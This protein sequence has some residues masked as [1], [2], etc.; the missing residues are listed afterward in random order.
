LDA[1]VG[2]GVANLLDQRLHR[3]PGVVAERHEASV[4]YR[5][6]AVLES[7][8][9]A[10][11]VLFWGLVIGR[12]SEPSYRVNFFVNRLSVIPVREQLVL[13]EEGKTPFEELGVPLASGAAD[14]KIALLSQAI[15]DVFHFNGVIDVGKGFLLRKGARLFVPNLVDELKTVL[16]SKLRE[17]LVE[18]GRL[19][20]EP[21]RTLH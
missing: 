11:H 3:L 2:I 20:D 15:L 9:D 8:T 10:A 7:L 5:G 4:P 21:E 1:G 17:L 6:L 13:G 19:E 16:R 12:N 14:L 18:V